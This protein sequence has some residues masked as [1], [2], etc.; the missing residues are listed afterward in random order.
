MIH[1]TFL[2]QSLSRL[3]S[4]KDNMRST[5]GTNLMSLWNIAIKAAIPSLQTCPWLSSGY[6]RLFRRIQSAS[7]SVPCGPIISAERPLLLYWLVATHNKSLP[8]TSEIEGGSLSPKAMC[9]CV[10]VCVFSPWSLFYLLSVIICAC[11]LS[12]IPIPLHLEA[13]QPGA[14]GRV[15]SCLK[16]LTEHVCA[17]SIQNEG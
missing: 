3:M 10:C 13:M 6:T 2:N 12:S 4:Y 15:C 8:R 7:H 14:E 5:V 11:R 1:V 17:Y 16:S 9:M